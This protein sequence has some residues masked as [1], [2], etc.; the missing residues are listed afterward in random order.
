MIAPRHLRP[1]R[2]ALAYA[3]SKGEGLVADLAR[4]M[5]FP[6]P[7]GLALPDDGM[8]TTPPRRAAVLAR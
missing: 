1:T 6:V 2:D 8:P 3:G 4:L 5:S 7:L